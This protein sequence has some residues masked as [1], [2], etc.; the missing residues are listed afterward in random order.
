MLDAPAVEEAEEVAEVE[1][2]EVP[3][4]AEQVSGAIARLYGATGSADEVEA[5]NTIVDIAIADGRFTTLV[6]LVVFAGLA[7][8]LSGEGPFTVF[9]PTDDAFA[10]LPEGAL[11]GLTQSPISVQSILGAHV[12]AGAFT[13]EDILALEELVLETLLEGAPISFSLDDD[14]NVVLNGGEARVII[15]DIIASNGV[16]HVIDAV[17]LEAPL[18]VAAQMGMGAGE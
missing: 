14:G 16:I 5:G 11:E 7:E 13:S 2:V 9:A 10:L 17:I 4:T 18:A 1:E 8:T 6:D 12:V 15:V 3:S